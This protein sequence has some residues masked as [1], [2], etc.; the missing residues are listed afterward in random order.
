MKIEIIKIKDL[1]HINHNVVEMV[2]EKPNNYDYKPGQ[3]TELAMN[4]EGWKDKKRPFTFTSLPKDDHLQ[5]TIKIYPSHDGVT[6]QIGQ[7]KE[8]DELTIGDVFG[9]I[10]YKG[11]GTFLAGGAGVTPF[12]SILKSLNHKNELNGNT[13]IFANKTEKDIFLQDTFQS[14][15]GERY[16][17]ILSEEEKQDYRHGHIDKTLLEN[18]DLNLSQYFYVCGPSKMTE[19]LIETLKNLGV[20]KEHIIAEDYNT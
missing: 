16:L 18:L 15:L 20:Q 9:A 6:E 5:F 3:A 19:D 17:N 11:K 1:K 4:K 2:T 8:G 10:N 13:L 12:I 7:L 14:F